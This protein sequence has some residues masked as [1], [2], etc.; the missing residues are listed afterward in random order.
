MQVAGNASGLYR[1]CSNYLQRFRSGGRGPAWSDT[2]SL[3]N[4]YRIADF[5]SIGTATFSIIGLAT[6]LR[7]LSP[8]SCYFQRET[9][10]GCP[11]IVMGRPL[12]LIPVI[13]LFA[14]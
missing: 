7:W 10:C 3:S 8:D 5:S 11:N 2:R 9:N 13:Y 6:L 14:L 12:C 4:D 1:T